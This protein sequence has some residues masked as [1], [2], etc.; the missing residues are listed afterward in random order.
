M[1]AENRVRDHEVGG[2]NVEPS[3]EPMTKACVGCMHLTR[4]R[5]LVD[6]LPADQLAFGYGNQFDVLVDIASNPS[7]FLR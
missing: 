1:K 2:G 4:Q 5:V 7:R 6:Q 3:Y